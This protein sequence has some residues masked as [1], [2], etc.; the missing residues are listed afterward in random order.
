MIIKFRR[1]P[2]P[3]LYVRLKKDPVEVPGAPISLSSREGD[4]VLTKDEPDGPLGGSWI[5]IHEA[6]MYAEYSL[7]K[8]FWSFVTEYQNDKFLV[9]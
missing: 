3:W 7:L 9:G 5:I 8:T 2:R 1:K 6:Y 4:F